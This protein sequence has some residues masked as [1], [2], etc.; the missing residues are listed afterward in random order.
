MKTATKRI[1]LIFLIIAALCV[2][3]MITPTFGLQIP[4]NEWVWK[5][6][7]VQKIRYY[8]SDSVLEWLN[9]ERPSRKEI[10]DKLGTDTDPFTPTR[11]SITYWLMSPTLIG[12][13]MYTL[14]IDFNEDGSFRAAGVVF[15]D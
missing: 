5:H 15:S 4:F 9:T 3:H 1:G 7:P 6:Y 10:M 8:M 12:L 11:T 14:E 2:V 13:A